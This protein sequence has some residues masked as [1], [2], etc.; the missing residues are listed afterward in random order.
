MAIIIDDDLGAA[1]AAAFVMKRRRSRM[2]TTTKKKKKVHRHIALTKATEHQFPHH[3]IA[4]RRCVD[5]IR[6]TLLGAPTT[7][8]VG[9]SRLGWGE[10][11]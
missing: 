7:M 2:T 4:M 8:R 6:Q 10:Y 11:T 5:G 3:P 1:V 9:M